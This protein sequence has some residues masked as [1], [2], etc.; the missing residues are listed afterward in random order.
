M[1][2]LAAR[3]DQR[4]AASLGHRPGLDQREAE[5]LLEYGV[6]LRVSVGAVAEAHA[7]AAV[8]RA[9]RAL[10]QD[11][12]HHAEIVDD[13]GARVDDIAPPSL[14]MEAIE[15]HHAAGS[16]DHRHCRYGERIHMEEGQRRDQPFLAEAQ[17]AQPALVDIALADVQ[18]VKVA[19]QAA[20]R[21]T[22]GAR[23]IEQVA[24]ARIPRSRRYRRV[25]SGQ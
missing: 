19:E 18:E 5:A 1:P 3:G 14:R 24:L 10:Q 16:E 6:V 7:M 15:L 12:R 23:G 2:W 8:L 9:G 22:G 11:R 17:R 13:R 4:A 20:L 21:L 25:E